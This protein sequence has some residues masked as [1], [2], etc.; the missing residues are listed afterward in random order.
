M[1]ISQTIFAQLMSLIDHNE[2]NR[3]VERHDGNKRVREFSCCDQFLCMIFSQMAKKRSL[4]DTVFTLQVMKSKLY[5]LGIKGIVSRCNL[6]NANER[7]NWRIYHDYAQSLIQRARDL[8]SD[9]KLDL[10][11]KNTVYAIDSSTIDL[12]LSIYE[13]AEFRSTKSG[14]KLHTVMDLKGSIPTLIDITEAIVSDN[15]FLDKIE[16]EKDAIY[17][18]NRGYCDFE[19]FRRIEENKAY[20]VT[21]LKR[22]ILFK[23]VYSNKINKSTGLIF[24]QIGFLNSELAKKKYPAK[25]RIIKYYDSEHKITYVFLTNNFELAALTI[26]K[27]YK[28]RWQIELFF[29][30]I[31]Q[32][33]HIESFFGQSENAVKLQIWIAICAYLLI[34][35]LKKRMNIKTEL[36]QILHFL[37]N[38]LFEQIPIESLFSNLDYKAKE[39]DLS[40]QL[41]ILD[42][43][44]RH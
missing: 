28:Q 7:R 15:Q 43:F 32:N 30:W 2:F 35:I 24:D 42:L 8:Y 11:L 40:N 19:R 22:N 18:M 17:V 14:I 44:T 36:S 25:V 5:H 10:E 12:C 13:W 37:S 29:K 23:R 9:E 20:F 1:P 6:A 34:V 38:V 4:R 41:S 33:L 27:L 31:K 16:I 39:S 21:R 3:C 26:C